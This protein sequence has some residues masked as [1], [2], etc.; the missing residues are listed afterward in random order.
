MSL[1]K[2]EE[3]ETTQSNDLKNNNTRLDRGSL[4]RL[5]WHRPIL[6]V[7]DWATVSGPTETAVSPLSNLNLADGYF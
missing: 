4:V 6:P 1:F 7:A 3:T 2:D 5:A